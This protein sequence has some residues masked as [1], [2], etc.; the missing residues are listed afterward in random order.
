MTRVDWVAAAI[1]VLGALSGLRRGLVATALSFGGLVAG[2]LIGARVAPHLL[3]GG[4]GSPYTPL[5]GLVGASVGASLLQ[6]VA[7][8]AGSFARGGLSVI[9]P[10]RLLDSLGGFVAGA[11]LGLALVWVAGAALLLIPGEPKLRVEVQKSK[12]LHRLDELAPPRTVLRALARV[13]PFPQIAGT[14][15]AVEAA[16]L[17]RARLGRRS[18]RPRQR[19]PDHR[20]GMRLR[21]RRLWL[22]RATAHRRHRGAR[23]RR[24]Q[25]SSRKRS[26]GDSS[27]RRSQA[28]RRRAPRAGSQD[29][30]VAPRRC[31]LGRSGCDSRVPRQRAVRRPARADREHRGCPRRQLA[32]RGDRVE[33]PRSPRQLG[34]PCGQPHRAGRGDGLRGPD[35]LEGRATACPAAPVRRA[36]A[37]AKGPVSTGSC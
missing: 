26:Q 9:P 35:R 12:I 4:A 5:A 13:D 1:A 23:R 34:R 18:Q 37:R 27:G 6:W 2:A 22:G 7:S 33:R 21:R 3:H 36:L 20:R 29:E 30:A 25:Q 31:A 19:R 15:A 8:M 32:A 17:A 28:G 24:R 11:G 14:G 10:L 16:G